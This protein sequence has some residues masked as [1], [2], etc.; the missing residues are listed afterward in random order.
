MSRQF[1]NPHKRHTSP[2]S[3]LC[4]YKSRC[5]HSS[6]INP[7]SDH[8]TSACG[9]RVTTD[10]VAGSFCEPAVAKF[11]NY[12]PYSER[13][14]GYRAIHTFISDLLSNKSTSLYALIYIY[15]CSGVP[16]GGVCGV[17]TPPPKF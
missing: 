11:R 5:R 15:I 8:N 12:C 17:Q 3:L 10:D 9:A 2:P 14:S 16:R 7:V 13:G 1:L 4:L 6:H